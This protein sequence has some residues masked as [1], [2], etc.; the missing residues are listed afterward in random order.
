[1]AGRYRAYGHVSSDSR[2]DRDDPYTH[3][4][5]HSSGGIYPA[6]AYE[7]NA[8]EAR[9]GTAYTAPQPTRATSPLR[10][11]HGTTSTTART[12]GLGVNSMHAPQLSESFFAEAAEAL[13]DVGSAPAPSTSPAPRYTVV[14]Q[15]VPSRAGAGSRGAGAGPH[16]A[17][18]SSPS[19]VHGGAI[20]AHLHTLLAD[21][22]GSSSAGGS[23]AE[24]EYD[25]DPYVADAYTAP[26]PEI[27]VAMH[28]ESPQKN[29][30]YTYYGG[31]GTRGYAGVGGRDQQDAG[32][33]DGEDPFH[34]AQEGDEYGDE[35]AAYALEDPFANVGQAGGYIPSPYTRK[36]AYDAEDAT[37]LADD[38]YG[39]GLYSKEAAE[40]DEGEGSG[41]LN[42]NSPGAGG[43]GDAA[44]FETQ[45]FG[46]APARGAQLRRHKT[47][48]N[49][50]LTAGN[51]VLDCPV[52][53]KLQSF[54]TRRGDEE[55][56]NM[57]YTAVTCDPNEFAENHYSLR[58][59]LLHRHT[60][61][62]ICITMYNED[63]NR[64]SPSLVRSILCEASLLDSRFSTSLP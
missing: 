21:A 6:D 56:M 22:H 57:R 27:E 46:P 58:P 4:H 19:D 2:Q 61:L 32:E 9:S 60:E 63:E 64:E 35:K 17:G 53:T 25:D 33:N 38:P 10:F 1:M 55:F 44:H 18:I 29:V 31:V 54:L 48:K 26:P 5:S 7:A 37:T 39:Y 43:L 36:T 45:H 30:G 11:G 62:F 49:V 20:T 50:K 42:A 28:G 23:S 3:S 12:G 34:E 40:E 41:F 52:P 51:L 8:A 47:K 14:A 59:A 15:P 16:P 24:R 13:S